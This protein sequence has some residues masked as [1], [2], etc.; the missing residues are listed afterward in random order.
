MV[1]QPCTAL[2]MLFPV[3]DKVKRTP[4]VTYCSNSL[5]QYE[6]HR[7]EEE[8][9]IKKDGQVCLALTYCSSDCSYAVDCYR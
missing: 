8:E 3:T 4:A 7:K 6:E 5:L 1:P 2:V 9:N